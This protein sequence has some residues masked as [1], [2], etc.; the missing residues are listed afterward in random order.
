MRTERE[1]EKNSEIFF[2][3]LPD[4]LSQVL[5]HKIL[6]SQPNYF[7]NFTKASPIVSIERI[8]PDIP[9]QKVRKISLEVR[10][11]I[12]I[13][14]FFKSYYHILQSINMVTGDL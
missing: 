1:G 7:H 3:T 5:K 10:R 4:R 8:F 14:F 12:R 6:L 2:A 13:F 11:K 9:A